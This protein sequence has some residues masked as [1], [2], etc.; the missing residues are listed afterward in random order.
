MI[1]EL[2][3]T[4]VS[5]R[6]YEN[7]WS[8]II[9]LDESSTLDD[10]HLPIQDAVGFDNDHLY[11]FFVS[12][13]EHRSK[14]EYFDDENELMFTKTFK[15][16]FP[17]P[18]DRC[19]FYLFDWGDEWIFKISRT[20]KR[21]FEPLEETEY[22]RVASESGVKP[23]QYSMFDDDDYDDYQ[24]EDDDEGEDEDDNEDEDVI[25]DDDEVKNQKDDKE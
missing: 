20:R 22:P 15:E 4:L 21:P 17:L 7:D 11:C 13:V 10:L 14:R 24:D 25:D 2:K 19:L 12:R 9:E 5:G 3:V 6:Y 16:M 23:K 8:A 1:I 18:K